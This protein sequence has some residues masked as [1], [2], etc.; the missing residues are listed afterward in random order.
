MEASAPQS[1]EIR[2]GGEGPAFHRGDGCIRG[3]H[4]GGGAGGSQ[5]A[6]SCNW[7][8]GRLKPENPVRAG[9]PGARRGPDVTPL[10]QPLLEGGVGKRGRD[11]PQLPAVTPQLGSWLPGHV[12][13]N[14]ASPRPSLRTSCA[15]SLSTSFWYSN[16]LRV[17]SHWKCAHLSPDSTRGSRSGWGYA[18]DPREAKLVLRARLLTLTQTAWEYPTAGDCKEEHRGPGYCGEFFVQCM[19]CRT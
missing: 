17:G 16:F 19:P 13:K 7:L 12:L 15:L 1:S 10:P 18:E 5:S 3:D 6:R 9:E 8:G 11:P 2:R 14:L 4:C